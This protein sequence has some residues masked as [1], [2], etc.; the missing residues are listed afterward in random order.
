LVTDLSPNIVGQIQLRAFCGPPV[1][2]GLVCL[3]MSFGDCDK[4]NAARSVHVWC[5][6]V[7]DLHDNLILSDNA[8]R[9]FT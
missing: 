8:F 3:T 2:A 6:V 7:S 1:E 5:A 4:S 9:L